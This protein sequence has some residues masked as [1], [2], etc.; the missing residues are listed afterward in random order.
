MIKVVSD[1]MEATSPTR[2]TPARH[3]FW[4]VAAAA[5]GPWSPWAQL[6]SV[7]SAVDVTGAAAAVG[8]WT[9]AY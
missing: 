3:S 4:A 5:V 2:A 1:W 9:P 8:E 7:A 6:V